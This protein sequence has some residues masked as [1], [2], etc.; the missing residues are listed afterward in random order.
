MSVRLALQEVADIETLSNLAGFADRATNALANAARNRLEQ[1]VKTGETFDQM[2]SGELTETLEERTRLNI[3]TFTRTND[4]LASA[5]DYVKDIGG[6]VSAADSSIAEL[7]L[8]LGWLERA[9][10]GLD[11]RE[12]AIL[13]A[14]DAVESGAT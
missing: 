12:A 3:Q 9:A 1:Q 2:L 6:Q 4:M 7:R 5:V 10:R 11:P 14:L 13:E 8:W